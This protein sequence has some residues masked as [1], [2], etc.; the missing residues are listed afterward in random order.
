MTAPGPA[1]HT[2][3]VATHGFGCWSRWLE[4]RLQLAAV[5]LVVDSAPKR[6]DCDR[7]SAA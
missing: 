1:D 5:G 2:G 3:A 6:A 4:S 7:G